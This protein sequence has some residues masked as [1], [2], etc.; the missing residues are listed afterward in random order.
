MSGIIGH[1]MYAV[2]GAKASA[3]RR[4][5]VGPVVERHWPTYLAGAYLGCDI[6]TMPEAVCVDTGK[7]V[8]YGT[9]PLDKSPRTGGPVRPF[10]FSFQGTN[11][12]PRDIHAL[13]YGRAHLTFGWTSQQQDLTLPWDHLPDYCAAVV[14]DAI[15]LYGP[16]ERP[17]AYIFGWMTHLVGD[18]L[19]KSIRPGV[20]LHLIDG[21]YTPRNRPIQDL[22]T[23]HE[24]GRKE[25]QFNWPALLTDLADTPVE[26]IQLHAM[27]V[28]PPRGR[29]GQDFPE[30]WR[31]QQQ[32][33]LRA[34][35]QENRRY[36][37]VYKDDVLEELKL[38]RTGDGWDCKEHLRAA[39]GGLHYAEM[40]E[41]AEKAHFRH[42]LWQIGEAVADLFEQ[43]AHLVPSLG[44]LPADHGPAWACLTQ[45]WRKPS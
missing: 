45:R 17:L 9:V 23:F 13:F 16:G 19:I 25:L 4:L 33:L 39:T 41:A 12:R 21:K 14:E 31:P 32:E 1:T 8:G 22:V 38:E 18:G 3:H 11:Y 24:I 43:V 10:H 20:E 5:P 35:L 36:L 7:E 28:A 44:K 6:Q 26:P 15:N 40:V 34:V 37:R 29:L 30:G 2:L 42:A 27:R